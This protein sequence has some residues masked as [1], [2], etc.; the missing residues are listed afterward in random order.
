MP[1]VQQFLLLVRF[2]EQQIDGGCAGLRAVGIEQ[3]GQQLAGG[4]GSD[5]E[6]ETGAALRGLLGTPLSSGYRALRIERAPDSRTA[7]AS[8]SVTLRLVRSSSVTPSCRSSRAMARD[9]GGWA[10]S[11]RW[12]ALPRRSHARSHE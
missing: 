4:A 8:V 11:R 5:G 10:I 1:V 7:P 3:F 12:A 9:R 2:A 6:D